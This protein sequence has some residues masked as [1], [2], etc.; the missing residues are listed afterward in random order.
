M[1]FSKDI[2]KKIKIYILKRQNSKN[3]PENFLQFPMEHFK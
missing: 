1:K 2:L 3:N